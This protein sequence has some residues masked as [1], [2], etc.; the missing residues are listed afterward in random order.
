MVRYKDL[1][2]GREKLLRMK[3]PNTLTI[4]EKS[5]E[6]WIRIQSKYSQLGDDINGYTEDLND[7]L[8]KLVL[9]SAL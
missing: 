2:R 3:K 8:P 6:F 9:Q 7:N 5:E 4:D 1:K